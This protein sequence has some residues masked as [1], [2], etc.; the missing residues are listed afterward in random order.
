MNKRAKQKARQP[1]EQATIATSSIPAGNLV[2]GRR[3]M[4]AMNT[5]YSESGASHSKGSLAGWEPLAS[6]PTSDIGANL[7]ELRARSRSLHQS[8]PIATSAIATSRTQTIGS[9]LKLRAR[10]D[11]ETLGITKE[12]AKAWELR[13]MKRFELWAGSKFCDL[14]KKDNWYDQQDIV[15]TGALL[16]GDGWAAIK[17]RKPTPSMPF[18]LR[19][20]LFEADRVSNPDSYETSGLAAMQVQVTNPENGNRIINGVEIDVDGAIVAYWVCNRYPYDPTNMYEMPKWTRVEA[21]GKETGLPNILQIGH[22]ERADQYRCVPYLA[23]V[24]ETLK[25]VSRYT[26]AE[27]MSAIIKAFFTIFFEENVPTGIG[28]L[29]IS[30][31]LNPKDKVSLDP[32]DFELGPGSINSLPPGY[33]VT[34]VDASRTLST[35]EPF[36]NQLIRQ[37]GAAIEQPYE[38]L[39][40]AFNSSY[41]ASRAALLQAYA[42]M[43]IRRTWFA[44]DFCQPIY[45]I[46]LTEAVATGKIDAPGFFDDIFTRQAWC[47]A[48][49]Y[50]PVM[51][52]LDPVKEAQGAILRVQ[53][54]FSTREKESAEM[55]GTD[56]DANLEQLAME[57]ETMKRLGITFPVLSVPLERIEDDEEEKGGGK[58]Q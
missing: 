18:M 30:E 39:L 55:T 31:T 19:I 20:H 10:V 49:W 9:G 24:I 22:N 38:V 12:A 8:A 44:R 57:Q 14:L 2:S 27:L 35:F 29:P 48:E 54:G 58:K 23:P 13:T 17:F 3:T 43:K 11:A 51:G 56:V 53:H 26:D 41:S 28:G 5:G 45:E 21:W 46:W 33:K 6:S 47:G 4:R 40:K 32:N 37:I 36:T 34:T 42:A 1:T 50:G 25:Q 15:F 7:P 16:N 52:V